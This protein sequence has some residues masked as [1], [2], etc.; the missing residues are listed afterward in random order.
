MIKINDNF[1]DLYSGGGQVTNT[2]TALSDGAAITVNGIKHTLSTSQATITFTL[3]FTGDYSTTSVTTT[4][5]SAVWTF[6]AGA[7]C[8]VDGV[9]SG[10]NTA[11]V[12]AVS[13]D[14]IVLSIW[15]ID[16]TDYRVVTKNFGQ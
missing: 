1:T 8:V 2:A 3:S 7:L 9:E 12:T 5:T 16:G 6:P 15:N 10:D 13:G 11:T 4:A 14:K